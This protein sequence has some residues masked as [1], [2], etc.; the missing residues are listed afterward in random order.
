M[1]LH[2]PLM[3]D[4]KTLA[5]LA[6]VLFT[7]VL[8]TGAQFR[9]IDGTG[10]NPL[11]STLGAAATPLLRR[12]PVAYEDGRS[13]PRQSG[14][15]SART[16]SNALFAQTGSLANPRRASDMVWQWGQFLDHDIDLT[17]NAHP[18]EPFDISVPLGD[19]FF[20]PFGTGVATIALKRSTYTIDGLGVRQQMNQITTWIDASNVYGSDTSRAGELRALDGTGR[21]KTSAQDLLPFNLNGFPNAGGPDPGLF[22]AGDAR[23][24]EQHGLIAMHTLFVREHNHWAD[25]F[26]TLPLTG[27]Q[28]YELARL[29]VWSEMQAITYNE[30]LPA[31]LGSGALSPYQG[32][33]PTVDARIAN[34]FSTAG[35]R[36]GHSM[37]SGTLK[38][39]DCDLDPIPGGPIAL[40]DTFFDPQPIID[41]G[42]EPLLR[43]LARQNAQ[44]VDAKVVDDVRN[45]LFGPPGA[46]GF[47][48]VSL[49]I[50]R[51]R[52]HG[53]PGY[54]QLRVAYGLAPKASFAQINPDP[55]VHQALASAY[56]HVDDVDAWVGGLAEPRLAFHG[57][58]GETVE[59]V[60]ADQFQRLRDGDALFYRNV[61][62]PNLV[63]FID[64]QSLSRII[65]RNTDIDDELPS[66]VFRTENYVLR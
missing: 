12:T 34:A 61:M 22:L 45:F 38:R 39:L 44:A 27:D 41:L 63:R 4:K 53:I 59:T 35:Y 11:D 57:L 25:W 66:N 54:N 23:S 21:L 62:P 15:P 58:V 2:T 43:G 7:L 16:V 37:L 56:S 9:S 60:L 18:E 10:N 46:G 24:N 29:I 6:P 14:L 42:I 5:Y 36:F 65:R 8:V 47:D 28:I 51:G 52:D 40:R 49:N 64:A 19:P 31:L 26:G 50:Q 17:D 13:I 48:L 20:D 33:D 30:F 32:Y 3:I 55:A 1:P